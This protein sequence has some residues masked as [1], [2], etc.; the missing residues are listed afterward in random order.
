MPS[1][2]V[3]EAFVGAGEVPGL[4]IW[5]IEKLKVVK[6]DPKLNG[7]FY[8]GD[9]Y[10]CLN[11]RKV[12]DK[13][14]WDIHFWLGS[15][16]T[17]DESG[18]AAYKTVELDDYLGGDPVQ[19]REVQRHE[20]KKFL[21]IF[22]NGIEYLEGGI[23][24]GFTKVDRDNYT[25]R[26]LHVKG[27][28][29]VRIEQ[30]EVTY[31]SLNHGDVFILDDGMTIYCWNGKDSSKRER[32]KAAEI[33][34]KIRDEERGGKG[35]VILIDSG[36]D[37]DKRFFEALGD[38]GL[39]KSAEEGG[40]DSEFEKNGIREIV[41]Y[42]V[43]D[44]SGEL[45]IEE[46]SRPPLKKEDL[47]SNDCFILDAGQSGVF[48]W[49]GKKCTQNEKKAAMNNA[50]KFIKE[51]GYPEYTKL[52]RV[53]EGGENPVFKQ[54]FVS[55][56]SECDQKGLGVLN[57]SNI[58]SYNTEAFEINK[59]HLNK[60]HQKK[61][62][63]FDDGTGKIRVWRINNFR[64]IDVPENEYGIF[65]E[66]DCYIVFYSYKE[67]MSDK[68][69]IYFW[70]GLKSTPDEKGASA[71]MAQ[72]LDDQYDGKPVQV[73]VVQGKEPDHF[74]LL[75]QHK[76]IIM[77]GGFQSGFN[78]RNKR[79][80]S[81]SETK[82]QP[83][84]K[85]FQIR[86]TTNL[87]TRAIEVNARA[88]SLNSNDVFLMKTLGNA[89]IWEG[90][91]ANEDEKAFAE[92][93]ADY[94]AP[95]GDLIIMREGK[96]TNEFWDLLGGKE[97]YAS[98]SR[99]SEKKPTIPPRLFQC[100]NATGRFWV[101]EIFDFDQDDL[102]E[103]DVMLLD[104]YD[105]VF[106]WIG[107]GANFIE[108]KNALDGA[109]EY[110]KSD[111]SGRTIENTNILR[112]KQGCEPLNFTGYFFAWDPEKWSKGMSYEELKSQLGEENVKVTSVSEEIQMF[113]KIYP[114]SKLSNSDLILDGVD[115]T[116]KEKHLSDDE[117]ELYF[118]MT[119]EKYS[120]LPKWKKEI[121]KKKLRLF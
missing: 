63:M 87:N 84:V 115:P 107:E 3:D 42:R 100:S 15:E 32:I 21:D 78:R 24:S 80:N 111:K 50:M 90:Q 103:D 66:G 116:N 68:Y 47:D 74:L 94:A 11:T 113:S 81:Y 79:A 41:L 31:K 6:Q 101:E 13:L 99:L 67:K 4:E 120:S 19:Y 43:T 76:M 25:K 97:E 18:V 61:N 108:K 36:K 46:A 69:V 119:K 14:E 8:N 106:V 91:G 92:I 30:V 44:S 54:F 75:F 35:Q 88:A 83:G 2:S 22:P 72:Q 23:E 37:N 110:I 65:Y 82:A 102:C 57:K 28:R 16:T 86:G 98:M 56:E 117:F 89:Y 5:R 59:L 104:T 12:R 1:T 49:I 51:K 53:V 48:S 96:E 38:K 93:V 62:V 73:R 10:I 45:K 85:L 95:D 55:W 58:A 9:S 121:L 105:E 114:Y 17:Q 26:L 118:G 60:D 112:V 7:K 70:Q 39:I 33:A 20:S 77:K 29:N 40:D 71:I 109:L 64:K 52:T 34:R 27:K